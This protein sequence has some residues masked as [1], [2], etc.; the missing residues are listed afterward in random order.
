MAQTRRDFVRRAGIGALGFWVAGCRRDLT[1]GEA[2]SE[3]VPFA[4]LTDAEARTLDALGEALLPGSADAGM[5]HYVDHQLG[6]SH[7]EQLLMIKYLGVPA[8]YLDFYRSGLAAV[9]R[10]ADA[11]FAAQPGDLSAEQSNQLVASLA[12]G[13]VEDWQGPPA[14]FLY[15]VLRSD[16]VDV[17]YGTQQGFARL[18]VPYVAHIEPPSDWGA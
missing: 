6:A 14:G 18:G 12:A 13:D 7:D 5:S 17:V 15:F 3:R 11:L 9:S 1:P 4:V 16:A 8:P 10:Q 2:R